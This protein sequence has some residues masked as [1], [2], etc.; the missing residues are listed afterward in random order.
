MWLWLGV[1]ATKPLS[2]QRGIDEALSGDGE[3][4]VGRHDGASDSFGLV[5]TVALDSAKEEI[6]GWSILGGHFDYLCVF[7]SDLKKKI[8]N[9]FIFC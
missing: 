3:R 4:L 6:G 5:G 2:K 1:S 9:Y 7:F 8:T